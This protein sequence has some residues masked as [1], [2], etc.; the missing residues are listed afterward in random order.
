MFCYF[1]Y[2]FYQLFLVG[3]FL[4]P[5]VVIVYQETMKTYPTNSKPKVVQQSVSRSNELEA[6][7]ILCSQEPV[8]LETIDAEVAE[9][10]RNQTLNDQ[11]PN[12]ATAVAVR[13][14]GRPIRP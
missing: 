5:K 7:Q 1:F 12:P 9:Y 8:N 2:K 11:V 3:R 13:A 10:Y 6:S 4:T 14:R